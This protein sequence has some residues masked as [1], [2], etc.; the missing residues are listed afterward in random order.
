MLGKSRRHQVWCHRTQARRLLNDL[1]SHLAGYT[2]RGALNRHEFHSAQAQHCGPL[3][4]R[5]K[6]SGINCAQVY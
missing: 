4:A 3:K 6:R 2:T 1:N 5:V